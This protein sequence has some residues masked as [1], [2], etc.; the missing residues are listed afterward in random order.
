MTQFDHRNQWPQSKYKVKHLA[1][2][3]QLP[4]LLHSH[5]CQHQNYEAHVLSLQEV[6]VVKEKRWMFQK[7][8]RMRGACSEY[9][10]CFTFQDG[11]KTFLPSSYHFT[12]AQNHPQ[13]SSPSCN[14]N[15][16]EASNTDFNSYQYTIIWSFF[17]ADNRK[18]MTASNSYVQHCQETPQQHFEANISRWEWS[19]PYESHSQFVRPSP[20]IMNNS[21]NL[22]VTLHWPHQLLT[23]GVDRYTKRLYRQL[24]NTHSQAMLQSLW[25]EIGDRL[26]SILDGWEGSGEI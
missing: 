26:R 24:Q 23:V 20:L 10:G 15:F 2:F 5:S 25:A 22:P 12:L 1:T 19:Q 18:G 21:D 7:H 6:L 9:H 14:H 13:G 4:P 8:L 17:T 16:Q 11:R 3:L